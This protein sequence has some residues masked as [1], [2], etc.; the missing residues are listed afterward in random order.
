MTEETNLRNGFYLEGWRV[1]PQLGKLTYEH[2]NAR[3]EPKIMDVLVLLAQNE[4]KVVKKE[5]LLA[6]VWEGTN[7]VD[8]VLARSISEIRRVFGDDPRN[9]HIIET[10]PKIGYKLIVPVQL[11]RAETETG[12]SNKASAGWSS[13]FTSL[14]P[15]LYAAG[16]LLTIF[17]FMVGFLML[18]H[19]GGMHSR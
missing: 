6:T 12:I 3:L 4:M 11:E 16:I 17:V 10:I 8:H 19:R 1:E 2:C 14:R 5:V 7:V 13:F 18:M 15:P 9:P